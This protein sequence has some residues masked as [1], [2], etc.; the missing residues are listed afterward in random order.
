MTKEE[1]KEL[2]D[3]TLKG[4]GNQV[5]L[6]NKLCFI[7]KALADIAYSGENVNAN[8]DETDP[9]DASFILN[10]PTIPA[11]QIQSDWNQTNSTAL[12]FI[13]NKPNIAL[14]I[15]EFS[16]SDFDAGS[17]AIELIANRYYKGT[18]AIPVGTFILPALG[19]QTEI[20]NIIISMATAAEITTINFVI[21]DGNGGTTTTG[22]Y[23][24]DGFDGVEA[25]Q[26]YEINALCDGSK[27]VI[28]G[29]KL[30]TAI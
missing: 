13:K 12:D 19:S 17:H 10:K 2:I 11:A 22:L 21:D 16:N 29:V 20:K 6:S 25:G 24:F 3:K 26:T 7:L 18:E 28:A 5:D 27:W 8:W 1:I 30:S 15:V 4:Q 9:T 23:M 14:P